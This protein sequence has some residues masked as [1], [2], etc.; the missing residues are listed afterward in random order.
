MIAE[1]TDRLYRNFRDSLT[2]EDLGVEI[3]LVKDGLVLSK[4]SKSQEKLIHGFHLLLAKNY[5]DNLREE[6][7]KGMQERQSKDFIQAG[8]R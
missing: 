5:S 7:R 8:L 6:V 4:E 3:H 1:T 2:L